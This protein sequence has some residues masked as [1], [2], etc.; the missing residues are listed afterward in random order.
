MPS[1]C[2]EVV[3]TFVRQR[4]QSRSNDVEW[5][6]AGGLRFVVMV[7]AVVVVVAVG[8]GEAVLRDSYPAPA[9]TSCAS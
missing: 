7:V 6:L 2:E 1:E 8:C 4:A 3:V 9:N 5:R